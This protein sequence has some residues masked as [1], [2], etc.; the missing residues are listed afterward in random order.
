MKKSNTEEFVE[1]AKSV[2]GDKYDY[3]KTS[4][5]GSSKRVCVICPIHGEFWQIAGYHLSGC[6]CPE[7][8]RANKKN[9]IFGMGEND[10]NEKTRV[11]SYRTWYNLFVRCYNEKSLQLHPTYSG[12]NVSM[13][14]RK[15]S[16]FKKWYDANYKEGWCIDKDLLVQGN[17]EYAP[18]KCCYIPN[19]INAFL[20]NTR[21]SGSNSFSCVYLLKNGHYAVNLSGKRVGTYATIDEAV[22]KYKECKRNKAIELAEKWKA[23]LDFKVYNALYNYEPAV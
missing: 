10:R 1:K 9:L 15:Y 5:Q 18:D 7:C 20:A 3:S 22:S 11:H 2:H 16:N 23:E 4:Y 21:R 14:W 19:E 13:E 6:D 12:C 8:A 17:K